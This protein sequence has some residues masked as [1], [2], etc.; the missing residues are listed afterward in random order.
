MN[1]P[2]TADDAD[3][4]SLSDDDIA[5][6]CD[7]GDSFPARA[8]A[9]KRQRL[10]RLIAEGFVEPSRSSKGPQKYQLTGKAQKFLAERGVGLN[11]S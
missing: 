10:E 8:G 11:E 1:A 9:V 7:V 5:V 6:L 2:G 4:P 3:G